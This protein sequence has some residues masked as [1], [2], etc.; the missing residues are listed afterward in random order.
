MCLDVHTLLLPPLYFSFFP[1]FA[2]E[3]EKIR[4]Y[5]EHCVIYSICCSGTWG[6]VSGGSIVQGIS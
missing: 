3:R 1:F 4:I 2:S 5:V 6:L